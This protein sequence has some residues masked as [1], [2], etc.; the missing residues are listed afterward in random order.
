MKETTVFPLPSENMTRQDSI[1]RMI[2]SRWAVRQG[3]GC[4]FL[5]LSCLVVS[6]QTTVNNVKKS[7]GKSGQT[8]LALKPYP[9]ALVQQGASLFRQ[10]CSFCHG[11]YAEGGETG[12]DL[13]RSKLVSQDVEGDRIGKVVRSGR[14][15]KGMPHFDLSDQQIAG[16]MAFI[17]TQQNDVLLRKGGRKGVDVS[18]LQTGNVE[19]GKRYFNGE[20]GCVSCHS[21]TGDLA[22]IASRYQGL[23]LEEQMLYP[24]P[25]KP[26][27]A[28]SLA[29]GQTI[30]GALAYLD[31]FT[32]GL[33]DSTGVYRSWPTADVKYTVDEPAKAHIDLF[34]KYTDSDIHN[35]MAYL[36]TLR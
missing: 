17:H 1:Y 4:V 9:T 29:S 16:I 11:R 25:V 33:K 5:L 3:I 35:L 10:N 15:D 21:P 18:D 7:A 24:E 14:P 32:V 30:T 19:A 6:G 31:E 36:Q 28:V 12:P 34:G 26:T 8:G 23:K 22:G 20:G 13:T 27:V 2:F